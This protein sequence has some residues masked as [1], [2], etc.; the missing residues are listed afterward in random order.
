MNY[1]IIKQTFGLYKENINNNSNQNIV[2]LSTDVYD[3]LLNKWQGIV[4]FKKSEWK[5]RKS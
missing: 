4:Y 1:E 5:N 3:K 2:E